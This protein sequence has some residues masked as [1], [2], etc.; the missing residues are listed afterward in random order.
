MDE[1]WSVIVDAV[2]WLGLVILA[3]LLICGKVE[4]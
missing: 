1:P 4:K 2:P 3:T